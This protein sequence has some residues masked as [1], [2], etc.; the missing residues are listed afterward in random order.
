MMRGTSC[1]VG[2]QWGSQGPRS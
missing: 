2:W 1:P